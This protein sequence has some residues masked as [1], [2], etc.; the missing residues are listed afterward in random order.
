MDKAIV[1]ERLTK[2]YFIG[3]RAAYTTFR[4]SATSWLRDR[5]RSSKKATGT[6]EFLALRDVSFDVERGERM[7][8]IGPNGAGKSTLLKIL[9]RVTE[10]THGRVTI[11]GR[12]SSLLEVGTG[13]HP[14]L[15]G[16]ENIYLNGA[17]LGMAAA[18]TRRKF[19]DI[20]SFAEVERFLDTPVKRYSSGMY[21]RLAFAVA[22]HLDPDVLILDEVLA[23]GDLRFQRKCFEKIQE[24]GSDERRTVLL[25]SHSMS[26]VRSMCGRAILLDNGSIRSL[27]P[28]ADVIAEYEAL[29]D[30]LSRF[31][32][33]ELSSWSNR[34]RN[35]DH[36]LIEWA[37]IQPIDQ[38][39]T[40]GG[41]QIGSG[42]RLTFSVRFARHDVGKPVK[43]AVQLRT[44]DGI[45]L[46]NM[47]DEDSNFA[48]ATIC[49]T[50]TVSLTLKDLRLYPGRYLIGFWVG[51]PDSETWDAVHD[52]ISLEMANVGG[53]ARRRLP[54][55][56][57]LLFLT[58]EW[59]RL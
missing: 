40:S 35:G 51:S 42:I 23:V 27:G 31:G 57:G 36:A 47:V 20:V 4:E 41:L 11:A 54:R 44:V 19:D 25:V 49:P 9:S 55:D 50:E 16:R 56:A 2:K 14:E 10:P 32:K 17:I 1:V 30:P 28:A 52:C 13:F 22:A 45:P 33:I 7:G 21:V 59:Q 26:S 5:F 43:L 34:T 15:T 53:L 39:G 58:P 48:I 29:F 46:A 18:E 38:D 37:D 6:E 24:A 8:I 3:H 12:V